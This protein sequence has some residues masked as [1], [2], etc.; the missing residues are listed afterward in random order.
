MTQ[1]V[2]RI[3]ATAVAATAAIAG[4]LVVASPASADPV[5]CGSSG[6][7]PR[8]WCANVKD[9]PNGL[10]IRSGPG[11]GYSPVGTLRNGQKV[12]VD[13]WG[14]GSSVNGY[15]IWVRLYSAAGSRWVSDL[16]LTT[17]HVQDYLIQC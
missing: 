6:S 16:Y 2:R 17:G 5:R 14:Y 4:S 15:R 11:T 3:A 7:D 10:T 8:A 13:C 9:A 1:R 12:E